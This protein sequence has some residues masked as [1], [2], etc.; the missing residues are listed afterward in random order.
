M[1]KQKL[2]QAFV[3]HLEKELMALKAAALATYEEAT[4]EESKPENEYDTRGLEASYLAGAQAKR[5]AAIDEILFL[6]QHTEIKDFAP[7]EAVANTALVEVE[8][9]S[10][11]KKSLIF[12]MPKGGGFSLNFEGTNVQ[13]ITPHSLVGE[14]LIGLRAGEVAEVDV[15]DRV[16]EYKILAVR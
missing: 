9:G 2:I 15:E 16:H 6:F 14:A 5:A 4:D 8:M 7:N 10:A 3:V 1:N 13:V 11:R 12:L